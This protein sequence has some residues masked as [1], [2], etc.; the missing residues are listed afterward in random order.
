MD[1]VVIVSGSRTAIG[2]LGGALK[3]TSAD[4]LGAV[5]I[6]DVLEKADLFPVTKTFLQNKKKYN[7]YESNLFCY[8]PAATPVSVDRIVM[9][10]VFKT[11]E[12]KNPAHD[13]ARK[14]GVPGHLKA[15]SVNN[16]F[17]SGMLSV[18]LAAQF[19]RN[20]EAEVIIAGGMENISQSAGCGSMNNDKKNY[21]E[22][23]LNN[24]DVYNVFFK[25]FYGC[26][27]EK[28][29]QNYMKKYDIGIKDQEEYIKLSHSRAKSAIEK[30]YFLDEIVPVMLKDVNN[31]AL[32]Y[33][34]ES[35]C[36]K[37]CRDIAANVDSLFPGVELGWPGINDGAAALLLMSGKK[38]AELGIIPLAK[39]SGFAHSCNCK[40]WLVNGPVS[41]VKMLSK[42]T[43][44]NPDM[45]DIFETGEVL[46]PQAIEFFRELGLDSE[47]PNAQGSAVS[48]GHPVGCSGARMIVSSLY[49]MRRKDLGNSMIVMCSGDGSA[50]AMFIER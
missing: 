14:A 2:A 42:K 36:V 11:L 32:F 44:I 26:S 35:P 28:T 13:A 17:G 39:I 21:D 6:R 15:E 20:G 27:I 22:S 43:G 46:C 5:V 16:L 50:M 4:E 25:S 30:G 9:G 49:Q 8:D 47:Y 45:F 23:T 18:A 34:D 38:A 7:C 29:S 3:Q 41:V 33:E 19:I 40:P 48:F 37:Q 12:G 24:S 31:E 10:N 1:N